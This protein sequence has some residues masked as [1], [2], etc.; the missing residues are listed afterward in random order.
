M[1][2]VREQSPAGHRL[3]SRK[4]A[5]EEEKSTNKLRVETEREASSPRASSYYSQRRKRDALVGFIPIFLEFFFS[6]ISF[7][8]VRKLLD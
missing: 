6:R 8:D 4:E 3:L 1:E 2:E 5:A 7:S